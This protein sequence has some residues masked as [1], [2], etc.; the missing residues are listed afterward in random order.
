MKKFA[1]LITTI[2]IMVMMMAQTAFAASDYYFFCD[3]EL[4]FAKYDVAKDGTLTKLDASAEDYNLYLKYTVEEKAT[5]TIKDL[6]V[7]V[8]DVTMFI[9]ALQPLNVYVYG[10]N[11]YK[12]TAVNQK[13]VYGY[14]YN[15]SYEQRT[16]GFQ[17]S[18][19]LNMSFVNGGT[20]SITAFGVYTYTT[21]TTCK[22]DICGTSETEPL[23]VN[24]N[25][26]ANEGCTDIKTFYGIYDYAPMD[27]T[28]K[29]TI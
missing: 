1:A 20:N 26:S 15:E 29:N 11:N 9:K 19:S 6:D 21:R 8:T 18:G 12:C 14:Y 3:Q 27:L 23:T 28:I 13:Y 25:A 24:I 17:G 22:L 7:E 2:A 10:E 4:E 5:L 16:M